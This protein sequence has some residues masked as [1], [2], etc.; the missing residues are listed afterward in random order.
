MVLR[1]HFFLLNILAFFSCF[2]A[3]FAQAI[4]S[5]GTKFSVEEAIAYSLENSR[6]LN[7]RDLD[8]EI[9]QQQ[10]REY[11]SIGLPQLSAQLDYNHFIQLPVTILPDEFGL[12]P[13]TGLVRDDFDPEVSFGT[14][15]SITP[16]IRASQML[17]NGSYLTGLKAAKA[18]VDLEETERLVSEQDIR[19]A[20]IESY[21]N[22]L[23]V[24]L[25]TQLLQKNLQVLEKLHFETSQ[26]YENGFVEQ[27]DIDRLDL[28]LSNLRMQI[29]QS[30]RN[31]ELMKRILKFQMRFPLDEP[32]DL[33]DEI[34]KLEEEASIELLELELSLNERP[35]YQV[36][37]KQAVLNQLDIENTRRQRLPIANVFASYQR[38][39]QDNSLKVFSEPWFP[40]F[41]VGLSVQVPIFN[42]F[43][44]DA[45]IKSRKLQS[46]KIVEGKKMMAD[47]FALEV[48]QGRSRMVNA[49]AAIKNQSQNL[50]LAEKIYT[51]ALIKYK[52]GIGSSLEVNQA[53]GS[54]Y[55]TQGLFVAALYDLVQARTSLEKA[56]GQK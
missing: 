26:L 11:R 52:E 18:L 1:S 42:G 14:K 33:S 13:M 35:E 31:E 43:R 6:Q 36:L 49:I 40:T 10:V 55:Q 27:L 41:L 23:I 29:G 30:L 12:D 44:T 37:N 19:F 32:I 28:S 21:Y 25:N 53:E 9:A 2:S 38:A 45:Q 51:T 39:F 3:V 15:N 5:T 50:E 8:I 7:D 17:F 54:L 56:L 24:E 46:L 47:G 20:V 34:Q 4:D 16:Q 22:V 48:E